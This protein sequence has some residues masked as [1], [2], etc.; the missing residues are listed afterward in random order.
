MKF[1]INVDN[2]YFSVSL[3]LL[4]KHVGLLLR[5]GYAQ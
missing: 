4:E 2:P 3:Q 5:T 1:N